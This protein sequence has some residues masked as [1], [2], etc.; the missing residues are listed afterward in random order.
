MNEE[1]L[2][3][4]EK[5]RQMRLRPSQKLAP[6][7]H[8]AFEIA[9]QAAAGAV[10][11]VRNGLRLN[12]ILTGGGILA[13]AGFLLWSMTT[14]VTVQTAQA[15]TAAKADAGEVRIVAAEN[16]I[17]ALNNR[18]GNVERSTI[19]GETMTEQLVIRLG[20]TPPPKA[21]A[22]DGGP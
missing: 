12:N 3:P 5:I 18:L 14:L 15:Q 22:A 16:A 2:T 21:A 1:N 7:I 8:E 4:E 11:P 17:A 20:M 6:T 19:R 9:D 10:L 13:V